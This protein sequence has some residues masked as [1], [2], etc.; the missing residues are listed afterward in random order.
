MDPTPHDRLC[1]WLGLPAGS[2]PP[3]HYL[4][5]GLARG[6]GDISDIEARV[7]DRMELL[8]PH[9]LLHPELVTEG[10]NRLA[11]ALVCL[12]DPVARA[13]YDRS[14]GIV[15]PPFEVVEDE[16]EP[17][18]HSNETRPTDQPTE[19]PFGP[20]L[21]PPGEPQKPVYE[22][23]WEPESAPLPSRIASYDLLPAESQEEVSPALQ[24]DRAN[25]PEGQEA[26]PL[27]VEAPKPAPAR[28]NRREVY[29]QLAVLRKSLRAWEGLRSVFGTP[30]ETLATPVAVLLF[31]QAL[32]AARDSLP[33]LA[34]VI[35]PELGSTILALV[36]LPH[37][38]HTVRTLLPSQRSEVALDWQ[39]GYDA[40]RREQKRLRELAFVAR[41]RRRGSTVL[42]LAH[43]VRRTPEWILVIAAI[44]AI[45]LTL[46]RRNS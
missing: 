38:I 26:E 1:S 45:L 24:S 12:T 8:R 20:G 3:D 6:A 7:L 36:R 4:L 40:L 31:M 2:W 33:G 13:P 19:V 27:P 39:R 35:R 22:V 32:T 44:V 46:L 15:A 29:R 28:I 37:A 10:M 18:K 14:L 17:P 30:T 9:Q 23:V 16:P 5:L 21:R 42:R 41:P 43:A 34:R 11:Q 25:Q